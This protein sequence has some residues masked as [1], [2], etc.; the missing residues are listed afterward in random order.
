[1]A[2]ARPT[3]PIGDTWRAHRGFVKVDGLV[4]DEILDALDH[5]DPFEIA[6]LIGQCLAPPQMRNTHG[7]P[8]EFHELLW[9]LADPKAARRAL[10]AHP[11][12]AEDDGT[13]RPT[14]DTANQRQTVILTLTLAGTSCA[15]TSTPTGAPTR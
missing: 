11:A 6:E 10:E 14:R 8:L 7:E 13:S 1:M 15:P 3:A 12:L 4:R 5:P 2:H 9:Q